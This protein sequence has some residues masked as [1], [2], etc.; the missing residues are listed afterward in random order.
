MENI[1]TFD[2][3]QGDRYSDYVYKIDTNIFLHIKR[4][5]H[6]VAILY[7]TDDAATNKINIPNGIIVYTYDYQ[8]K[9]KKVVYEPI[10]QEY[11]LCWTDNYTI[12]FN[13][14]VLINL[15][16]QRKWHITY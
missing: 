12:E 15:Q 2:F 13:E 3:K 14:C 4:A 9:H 11:V 16:N 1:N 10:R 7:F 6:A 8:N 5:S